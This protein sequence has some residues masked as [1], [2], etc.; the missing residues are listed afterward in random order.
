[1]IKDA[2]TYPCY[3]DLQIRATA[4]CIEGVFILRMKQIF[5]DEKEVD[6]FAARNAEVKRILAKHNSSSMLIPE[7]NESSAVLIKANSMMDFPNSPGARGN[8]GRKSANN[9]P[10]RRK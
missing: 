10:A 8:S 6:K 7:T 9:S 1:M 5:V 2:V 4:S 3:T